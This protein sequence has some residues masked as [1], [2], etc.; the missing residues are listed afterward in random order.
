[1][2]RDHYARLGF[3]QLSASADGSSRN[4]LELD[5]YAPAASCISVVKGS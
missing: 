5:G 2:V 4:L 3:R 1:M